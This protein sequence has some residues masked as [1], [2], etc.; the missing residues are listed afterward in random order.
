MTV[1]LNWLSKTLVTPKA[2]EG[3]G[4][5][6]QT[7]SGNAFFPA[8][9]RIEEVDIYDIAHALSM[10]CR[11]GGHIDHHYSV[12]E[13]SYWVSYLVPEAHALA[14]LMHDAT[15]AYLVD[16]PR[17]VKVLLPEYRAIEDKLWHVIC[18]RFC[19]N[20]V[21]PESVGEADNGILFSERDQGMQP[22]PFAWKI[23]DP[24]WRIDLSF[25]PAA[26]A[27]EKFI[28]RFNE[29]TRL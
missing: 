19:I 22:P 13:H 29:L 21:L 18:E 6:M 23:H 16:V 10:Q 26:R 25:W 12:A 7:A 2:P 15:E 4:D 3:R 11:F 5:W 8:D 28:A 20:P 14:A 24:G 9:P 1:H 27:R 17:P